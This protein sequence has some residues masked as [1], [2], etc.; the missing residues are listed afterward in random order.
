MLVTVAFRLCLL[1][2]LVVITACTPITPETTVTPLLP[3]AA[4]GRIL[5]ADQLIRAEY[6]SQSW[7]MQGA[8]EATAKEIRLV[9]LNPLGQRIIVLHWDGAKLTE[10]RNKHFP[11]RIKGDRIL[12]DIQLIYWPRKALS[13][14]LSHAWTVDDKPGERVVQHD[15]QPFARIRCDGPDPWQ[16][17]CVFEQQRY[18][19]LLTIDSKLVP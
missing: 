12:S 15:N 18:G 16:G 8:V 4:L 14:A 13:A 19:Y 3:P 17:R 11:E 2:S 7:I 6:D 10:E 1:T 5:H 9:G